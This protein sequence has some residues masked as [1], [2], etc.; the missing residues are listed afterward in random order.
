MGQFSWIDCC[1]EKRA[2]IDNI[3]QDVYVLVP[4]EF[5]G[6]NIKEECYDGYG[7]FGDYDIYDLVA[8]W[9][10]DFVTI[11][12]IEKPQRESWGNTKEDKQYFKYALKEYDFKC[13]RLLDFQNL[14]TEEM[15]QKYSKNW[16]REIGIDI[17]C[18]DKRNS[19]L[20]FPIK[21]THDP[22]AIYEKCSPS[23]K[24]P[25]QGWG[26]YVEKFDKDVEYLSQ[27]EIKIAYEESGNEDLRYYLNEV[28]D[29]DL[30]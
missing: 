23:K 16:L 1:N 15:S 14:T 21:I 22:N 12:N 20:K 9:N 30:D 17:A 7:R 11:H 18:G 4:K 26:Y 5:G 24:D 28:E 25:S 19:R 3:Y 6:Q 29:K 10:K 13:Q 8:A 2:V 27:E